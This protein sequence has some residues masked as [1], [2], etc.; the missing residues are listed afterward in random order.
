MAFGEWLLVSVH[1]IYRYF[2]AGA[3]LFVSYTINQVRA[4][5]DFLGK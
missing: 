3:A 2:L 5:F 4:A 1:A